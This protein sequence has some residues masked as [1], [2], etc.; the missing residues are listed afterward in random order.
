MN[1]FKQYIKP[2]LI[3]TFVALF[4][5]ASYGNDKLRKVVDLSGEWKFSIG[6]KEEW[7]LVDFDDSKW[8][9]VH[10]PK[11]WENQGFHG[12]DGY[13]WYRTAFYYSNKLDK[14]PLYLSLGYI[15]DVD[16]VY[17]N[18][19][20]IGK[21]GSFPP[22]YS[23]AYNARR[24]YRVPE[25]LIKKDGK[26][27]IAVRIFD[28][29]GEGGIV[30]G[31]VSLMIDIEA[32]PIDLCLHGNWKFK[33][34]DCKVESNEE[35]DFSSWDDILVPGYWED[36]GYKHYDGVA[37]YALKFKLDK[38]F[39]GKYMVLLMGKIDDAD[40]IYLNGELIGQ[41]GSF[42]YKNAWGGSMSNQLRGYY[43]PKNALNNDGENVIFVRVM[44]F[45]GAGGIYEG[46][47]GLITQENY[48][49]YWHARRNK[50]SW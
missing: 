37:C 32:I 19:K 49:H 10:V 7:A 33:I 48:I 38:Q 21:T 40:Q 39:E 18:G 31:D 26:N 12:Y 44:D 2:F 27:V 30:H 9:E 1:T 14:F 46:Q 43:L 4:I 25:G 45:G 17:F 36:Q 50:H 42:N 41:S 6:D 34:N 24:I 23:T 22:Y 13:G 16:E 28:D 20:L 3:L 47:I 29:G 11:S 15:D 5:N 8:E 35:C